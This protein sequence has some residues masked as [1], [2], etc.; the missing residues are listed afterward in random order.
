MCRFRAGTVVRMSMSS[1][2]AEP[3]TLAD[4]LRGW[5]DEQVANLLR[6]RPDL[7][8]PAPQDSSQLAARM[9][10]RTSV[11]RAVDEL[12]SFELAVLEAAAAT[13]GTT[14]AAELHEAVEG[15][16]SRVVDAMSRL[17]QLGL[18]WGGDDSL[19]VVST[20]S[21]VLGSGSRRAHSHLDAP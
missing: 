1:A 6:E 15:S 9:G 12:T 4:Q 3:R 19:R 2:A 5:S 18:L 21:T 13:G 8:M 11:L 20:V 7:A 16:T 14:S 10:N 17:Q